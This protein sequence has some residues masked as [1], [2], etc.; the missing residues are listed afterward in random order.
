[1]Y[2]STQKKFLLDFT[3][4]QQYTIKQYDEDIG[5]P[6]TML[7]IFLWLK[8]IVIKGLGK[9]SIYSIILSLKISKIFFR[10]KQKQIKEIT[11][12]KMVL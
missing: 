9:S 3:E 8:M 6:Y 5:I 4:Q 2:V 12:K 1:M 10:V 7:S 11:H